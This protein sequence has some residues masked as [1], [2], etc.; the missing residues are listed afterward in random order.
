MGIRQMTRAIEDTLANLGFFIVERAADFIDGD[1]FEDLVKTHDIND[2][3]YE[4]TRLKLKN[5]KESMGCLYLYT[6]A[7]HDGNIWH[8]IIDGSA[9]PDDE[10]EFSAM[11]DE[12]YLEEYGDAFFAALKT[13]KVTASKLTDQGEWGWVVSV[14]SP[15]LNSSGELVGIIGCDFDGAGLRETIVKGEKQCAVVVVISIIAGLI[16]LIFFLQRI[17]SPIKKISR[18]LKEISMGEGDLTKRININKKGEVGELASYF[19]MTLDKIKNLVIIIK[20]EASS[21]QDAGNSL[22]SNM[23]QTAGAIHE[24]TANI[25]GIKRKVSDQSELLTQTHVSMDQVTTSIDKLDK[26]V[27][28]QTNSVSLSSSA[29][30]QMLANVENVTK[31][32]IRNSENVHEL[33]SVSDRGRNS[34]QKVSQDIKEIARESEGLLAINAVMENISSQ[35]NLLSMN[36]AI[37]AAHAGETGKGFAVVAAEIRKLANNAAEQSKTISDVLKKIKTAIDM[38]THST[39]TVLENFN[40]I[41]GRVHVVSDQED[42]IRSAMEEQG[43]GSKQIL[44]AV[45]VLNEKT[46]LVKQ[47]SD[48]MLEGSIEVIKGSNNLQKVTAEISTDMKEMA[49]GAEQI[50]VA[51]NHVNDISK[52]TKGHIET[53]FSEVSKF[54]VD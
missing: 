48:E 32:L 46:Q 54:K 17:F 37:E 22:A 27:E 14:Y 36:A 4:E 30:Q 15:I 3:F 6:T 51:V 53:L 39:N 7:P 31:T 18:I 10:E 13:H 19:N 8:Y 50:S 28:V 26:N 9:E 5:L 29:I 44:Q 47:G 12:D 23:Q 16:L 43:Q 45:S 24:I 40:A 35:T 11:G 2:P 38:I 33:I 25:Q 42:N 21:L 49:Y 52:K 34:L 1:A 41:D 20:K